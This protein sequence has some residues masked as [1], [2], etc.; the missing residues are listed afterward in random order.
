MS[1][2]C[3]SEAGCS[4][5]EEK[6]KRNVQARAL[7][8]K[9]PGLSWQTVLIISFQLSGKLTPLLLQPLLLLAFYWLIKYRILLLSH[10]QTDV[11]SKQKVWWQL[12]EPTQALP[13]SLGCPLPTQPLCP[14]CNPRAPTERHSNSRCCSPGLQPHSITQEGYCPNALEWVYSTELRPQ[15]THKVE[16]NNEETLRT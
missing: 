13:F 6:E 11:L 7:W 1:P 9:S 2:E 12:E 14:H 3:S 8:Y 16:D 15:V 4:W 5:E 10:S